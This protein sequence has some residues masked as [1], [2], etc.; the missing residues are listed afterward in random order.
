MTRPP[1]DA[2]RHT[3]RGAPRAWLA[4]LGRVVLA[5][6]VIVLS[7]LRYLHDLVKLVV[8]SPFIDFAHYYTYSTIV[9]LRGN[10]FDAETIAR[11]DAM[12][13]IRRA[14]AAATYPPFFSSSCNRGC[15]CRFV[16]RRSRGSSSASPRIG[17]TSW[18]TTCSA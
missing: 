16:Q 13:R 1:P 10:P 8:E 5:L 11:V 6:L 7:L 4:L 17:P 2:M 15:F 9:R 3:A 18:G 12:L 14:G